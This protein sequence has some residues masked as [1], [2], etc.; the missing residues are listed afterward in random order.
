MPV[1][2]CLPRIAQL[3]QWPLSVDSMTCPTSIAVSKW[4][5]GSHREYIA[6]VEDSMLI[7]LILSIDNTFTMKIAFSDTREGA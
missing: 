5:Q 7:S 4:K 3:R 1:V 6:E 2:C